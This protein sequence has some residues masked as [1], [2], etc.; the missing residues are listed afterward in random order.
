MLEFLLKVLPFSWETQSEGE[1][2]RQC[3]RKRISAT[4][5]LGCLT[6]RQNS[7]R[8]SHIVVQRLPRSKDTA[9]PSQVTAACRA[10]RGSKLYLQTS[11]K[12]FLR[13][14][15]RAEERSFSSSY[16]YLNSKIF[17]DCYQVPEICVS[18]EGMQKPHFSLFLQHL[19]RAVAFARNNLN[20]TGMRTRKSGT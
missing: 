1:D 13:S 17:F 10:R 11:L 4:P 5:A 18:T 9:D 2:S 15:L 12:G 20:I 6:Q 7:I 14:F 19:C 8:W 3:H 16:L